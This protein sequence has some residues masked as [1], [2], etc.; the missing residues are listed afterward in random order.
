MLMGRGMAFW[1]TNEGWFAWPCKKMPV[2]GVRGERGEDDE[3]GSGGSATIARLTL[4]RD[5]IGM[6]ME[7]WHGSVCDTGGV[8]PVWQSYKKVI[9]T[10]EYEK[11]STAVSK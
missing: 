3:P 6:G 4:D 2:P 10:S 11:Q 7:H 5:G 1:N 8:W 9:Q